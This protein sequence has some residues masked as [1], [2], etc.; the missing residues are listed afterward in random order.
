MRNDFDKIVRSEIDLIPVE[1]LTHAVNEQVAPPRDLFFVQAS[2]MDFDN[3]R[4][5][6]FP[7]TEA[8]DHA[9][10]KDEVLKGFFG[11]GTPTFAGGFED[12][13]RRKEDVGRNGKL[14]SDD[15]A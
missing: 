13:F 8:L 1:E 10:M 3:W 14:E 15:D 6:R 11:N 4:S 5:C 9:E 12:D 2:R 7:I